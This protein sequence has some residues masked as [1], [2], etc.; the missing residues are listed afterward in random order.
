[1][2]ARKM[3]F[4]CFTALCL[5]S[6]TLGQEAIRWQSDLEAAKRLAAETNRHVLIHF[7]ATWCNPCMA[8]EQS[9]F[10]QP[11]VAQAIE[12]HYVPVKLNVDQ[13][14]S[15]AQG[16]GVK[17][18]P[19]D[20]IITPKGEVVH[21]TTSPPT[22]EQYV[23]HMT[24]AVSG[25]A[26]ASA[27]QGFAAVAYNAPPAADRYGTPPADRGATPPAGDR[28]ADYYN[29]QQAH[30]GAPHTTQTGPGAQTPAPQQH[31]AQPQAPAVPPYQQPSSDQPGIPQ[32]PAWQHA[33]VPP[34]AGSQVPGAPAPW[35][36]QSPQARTQPP[37]AAYVAQAPP[38]A[39]APPG[40][41]PL[42]LDGFCPVQLSEHH[43]WIAGDRRWGAIHMGRTY[44]FTGPDEQKRFLA[45]PDRYSPVASG[46]DPVLAMDQ[47][48]LVPG[49]R[50]H[51]VFYEGRVFLFSSEE[52]LERFSQAPNRYAAEISQA[53]R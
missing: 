32:A 52:S 6:P 34:R 39:T 19:T 18:I 51:G 4:L 14:G 30:A 17:S 42:G 47:R 44:L 22:A 26:S 16:Y 23:A 20:V 33:E 45:N 37:Q 49:R 10:Q 38:A 25:Q 36:A 31:P 43:R 29:R 15:V 24:R 12:T 40:N 46:H 1:M 11:G 53:M 3:F 7:W 9:V 35:A 5:A 27:G 21:K 13:H 50:E 2:P 41:P 28:Y 8:L 48:Q